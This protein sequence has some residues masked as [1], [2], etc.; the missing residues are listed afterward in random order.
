MNIISSILQD[1]LNILFGFTGDIGI[2]IV[3]IT[4]LVKLLLIP[5]TVKQKYSIINSKIWLRNLRN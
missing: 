3:I 4:L 2:S 5:L 1:L